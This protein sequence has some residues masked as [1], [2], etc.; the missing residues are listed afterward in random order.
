[1]VSLLAVLELTAKEG[2][3]SR[4]KRDGGIATSALGLCWEGRVDC[5]LEKPFLGS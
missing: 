1:M 2:L 4:A 3:D 5:D